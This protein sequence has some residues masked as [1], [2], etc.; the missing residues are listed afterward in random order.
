MTRAW[1]VNSSCCFYVSALALMYDFN[2]LICL[3][4]SHLCKGII[5]LYQNFML[6]DLTCVK[7]PE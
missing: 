1:A 7:E 3:G 4:Q 5:P 2:N 6:N